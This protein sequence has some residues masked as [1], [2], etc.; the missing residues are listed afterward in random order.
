[1]TQYASRVDDWSPKLAAPAPIVPQPMFPPTMLYPSSAP[2]EAPV[3]QEQQPNRAQP[4]YLAPLM[5]QMAS[6]ADANKVKNW[7]NDTDHVIMAVMIGFLLL[8]A[9]WV[10]KLQLTVSAIDRALTLTSGRR[11]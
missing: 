4:I 8:L 6:V 11:L 10:I 5:P 7:F 2:P 1:M 3:Q 9:F